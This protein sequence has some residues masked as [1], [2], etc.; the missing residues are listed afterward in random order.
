MN[1]FCKKDKNRDRDLIIMKNIGFRQVNEL[2][3]LAK[4]KGILS[5]IIFNLL[6]DV[7]NLV[8]NS[9]NENQ[10]NR[11]IILIFQIEITIRIH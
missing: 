8:N 4:K 7:Y 11:V 5:S 3:D 6:D 9:K 1:I 2:R 10:M